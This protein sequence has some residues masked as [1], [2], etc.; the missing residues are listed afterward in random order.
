MKIKIRQHIVVLLVAI[1]MVVLVT[2]T[3]FAVWTFEENDTESGDV[4]ENGYNIG[5]YVTSTSY[6]GSFEIDS[7]TTLVLDVGVSET[8]LT[9]GINFFKQV[10]TETTNEATS[11]KTI[12][13]GTSNSLL[14]IF[15]PRNEDYATLT[16]DKKEDKLHYNETDN[17]YYGHKIIEG[18][19]VYNPEG[20]LQSGTTAAMIDILSMN[21]SLTGPIAQILTFRELYT[22]LYVPGTTNVLFSSLRDSEYFECRLYAIRTVS[23]DIVEETGKPADVFAYAIVIDNIS[24]CLRYLS[25]EMKPSIANYEKVNNILTD[26]NG[27]ASALTFSFQ[28]EALTE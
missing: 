3:G 5:V 19:P 17:T 2:G 23:T 21:I 14:V 28:V 22:N 6:K 15:T 12:S 25:S 11:E 16:S 4:A 1:F 24:V 26:P 7:P 20:T 27:G 8:S 10:V 18:I 13:Y 9:T